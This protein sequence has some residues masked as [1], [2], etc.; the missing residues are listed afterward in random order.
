MTIPTLIANTNGQKFRSQFKKTISTLS[1]AGRMSQ[2]QYG[3]DY[4]GISAWGNGNANPETEKTIEALLNGTVKGTFLGMC[5]PKTSGYAFEGLYGTDVQLTTFGEED[6][7]FYQLSDGSLVGY[8][9]GF[10]TNC[11]LTPGENLSNVSQCRGFIDVNGGTKPNKEVTC[12]NGTDTMFVWDENYED[13]VVKNDANHMTDIFPI[14]F[15]DSI[16]EPATNAAKY[17]LNTAK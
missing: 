16:V 2:A 13:C 10:D 14:V 8:S 12:S 5:T 15:H 1:Q 4:A 6:M 7:Y 9:M 3:F 11:S 17:V